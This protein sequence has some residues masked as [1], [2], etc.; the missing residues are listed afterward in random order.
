[1]DLASRGLIPGLLIAACGLA[2]CAPVPQALRFEG[3]TMG[4]SYHITVVDAPGG[5]GRAKYQADIDRVLARIDASM[6]TWRDDSE[7]ARLNAAPVGQDFALSPEL[8]IGR[9]HV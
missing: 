9:A 1:M 7:I 6:S 3:P 4:T 2:G 8:Q 5:A